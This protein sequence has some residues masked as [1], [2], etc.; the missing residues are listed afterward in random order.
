MEHSYSEYTTA[1]KALSDEVRLKILGMLSYKEMCAC[2]ILDELSISQST[3][4]Y[5]MNILCKSGL[6][7]SRRDGIWMKYT[8]NKERFE[9]I[10]ELL[11]D[12]STED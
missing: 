6:A 2:E 3:L 9:S 5:H 4:S 11:N 10:I 12:L 8:L 1:F 7:I